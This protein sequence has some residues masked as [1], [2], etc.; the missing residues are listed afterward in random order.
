MT[1]K[2]VLPV[3]SCRIISKCDSKTSKKKTKKITLSI[4]LSPCLGQSATDDCRHL[5]E[6]LCPD[7]KILN[8]CLQLKELGSHVILLSND[9]NLSIKAKVNHVNILTSRLC[10]EKYDN[11]DR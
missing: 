9:K 2:A 7:D 3:I 5:I 6:I 4:D 11:D 10:N 1:I 8:C